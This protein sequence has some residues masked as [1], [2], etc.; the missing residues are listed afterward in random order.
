MITV[1]IWRNEKGRVFQYKVDGHAE[2]SLVC[3][4]VSAITQTAVYGL[5][6]ICNHKIR[7]EAA[8]GYLLV[9]FKQEP[10]RLTD[11][12]METMIRGLIAIEQ[13]YNNSVYI[14]DPKK[15]KV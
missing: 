8:P 2:E 7:F 10:D 11:V 12:V 3:S 5:N 1:N 6:E 9:S 14:T 13:K 15:K 4:A